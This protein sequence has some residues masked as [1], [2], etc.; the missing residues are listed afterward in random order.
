[1]PCEMTILR[2]FNHVKV[3]FKAQSKISALCNKDTH[4]HAK[5]VPLNVTC[6]IFKRAAAVICDHSTSQGLFT[7][8]RPA[9][10]SYLGLNIQ[11]GSGSS[12]SRI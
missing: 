4:N 11:N 6:V 3:L 5:I 1:M 12:V 10:S 8:R 2:G 7:R 9:I